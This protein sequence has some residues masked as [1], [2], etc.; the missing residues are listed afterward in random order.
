MA[1]F[2]FNSKDRVRKNGQQ[3]TATVEKQSEQL[4]PAENLYWIQ[5]GTDAAKGEWA[6]ESDLEL[7]AAAPKDESPGF[8]PSKSIMD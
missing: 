8:Y 6:K 3:Q 1:S 2:K 5:C 7:V 4:P